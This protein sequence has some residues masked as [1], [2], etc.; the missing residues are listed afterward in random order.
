LNTQQFLD[1]WWEQASPWGMALLEQYPETGNNALRE[2]QY[3]SQN[4]NKK[5]ILITEG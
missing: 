1:L 2:A 3:I 4:I 5:L